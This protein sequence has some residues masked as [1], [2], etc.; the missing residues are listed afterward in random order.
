MIADIVGRSDLLGAEILLVAGVELLHI[1]V[2]NSVVDAVVHAGVTIDVKREVER[3]AHL[4]L[5]EEG[6]VTL[7]RDFDDL[8]LGRVECHLV[9]ARILVGTD[10]Q[11]VACD[12]HLGGVAFIQAECHFIV[13]A[14]HRLVI[15][16]ADEPRGVVAL[17]LHDD[18]QRVAQVVLRQRASQRLR[19]LDVATHHASV[20]HHR[21]GVPQKDASH[22]LHEV[23][24]GAV[25][26]GVLVDEVAVV[27]KMVSFLHSLH[28]VCPSRNAQFEST[29]RVGGDE[30]LAGIVHQLSVEFE[31]Y[32]RN[33]NG[34]VAVIDVAGVDV[35][36]V[37]EEVEVLLPVRTGREVHLA[38][39]V[40]TGETASIARGYGRDFILAV[41]LI[42]QFA[43]CVIAMIVGFCFVD[44]VGARCP[45]DGLAFHGDACH[46]RTV[47]HAH[48]AFNQTCDLALA[49]AGHA[50]HMGAFALPHA[51]HTVVVCLLCQHRLVLVGHLFQVGGEGV[52]EQGFFIVGVL[53]SQH[54]EEVVVASRGLPHQLHAALLG[55]GFQRCDAV[56]VQE[57]VILQVAFVRLLHRHHQG[58]TVIPVEFQRRR[59]ADDQQVERVLHTLACQFLCERMLRDGV[60][61]GEIGNLL[62]HALFALHVDAQLQFGA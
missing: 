15:L 6:G 41:G 52:G 26:H 45:R 7:C 37:E 17:Q 34:G 42:G 50:L 30:V 28:G 4:A 46:C 24:L 43:E 21:R 16:L 44:T 39:G 35:I 5:L 1:H 27:G 56:V 55:D 23:I 8:V 61:G 33:R 10:G 11:R 40:G 18:F 47:R 48:I 19:A 9:F 31:R 57:T 20:E 49:R 22:V 59:V 62:L 2:G 25:F 54:S 58:V 13:G 60:G 29:L 14:L 12:V 3:L 53:A 38:I 36:S 51:L 32:A